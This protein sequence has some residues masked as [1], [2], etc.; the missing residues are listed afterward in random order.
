LSNVRASRDVPVTFAAGLIANAGA[1]NLLFALEP[2]CALLAAL[3]DAD[4]APHIARDSVVMVVDCGGKCSVPHRR[5]RVAPAVL[6]IV[7][8]AAPLTSRWTV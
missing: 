2:E 4:I 5:G 3:A 7:A 8:Q 1:P 6:G